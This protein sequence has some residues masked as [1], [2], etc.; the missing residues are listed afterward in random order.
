MSSPSTSLDTNELLK[1][2][3]L[4]AGVSSAGFSAVFDSPSWKKSG[5]AVFISVLARMIS[6]SFPNATGGEQLSAT[7]KN[8]LVVGALNAIGAYSMNK[9][10]AKSVLL[11]ISSDLLAE[12]AFY[13]L[14]MQDTVLIGSQS[15]Q[16]S[17]ATVVPDVAVPA[18]AVASAQPTF[19]GGVV[20]SYSNP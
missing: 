15:N 7:Q 14:N 20:H 16:S 5:V 17:V 19:T 10:V 4:L 9:S 11:G 6:K 2:S 1:L 18:V 3:D 13:Y 8:Q 12:M